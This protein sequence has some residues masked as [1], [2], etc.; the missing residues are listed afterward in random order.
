MERLCRRVITL[1]G[2]CEGTILLMSIW[3]G[4]KWG[5]MCAEKSQGKIRDGGRVKE[6]MPGVGWVSGL[7]YLTC[8]SEKLVCVCRSTMSTTAWASMAKW[9]KVQWR[10]TLP[11]TWR[12]SAPAAE[13]TRPWRSMTSRLWVQVNV[14]RWNIYIYMYIYVN[15]Y[16]EAV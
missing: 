11:I 16:Q 8:Q 9:K 10:S 3:E 12:D 2:S 6:R 15:V 4:K 13:Q 1:L 14:T 7:S 5:G